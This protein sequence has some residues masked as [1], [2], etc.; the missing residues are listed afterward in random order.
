MKKTVALDVDGVLAQYNGWKGID[1]IGDP[2]PG[3]ISFTKE[4]SEFA[5]ILIYTTRCCETLNDRDGRK[6]SELQQIVK[7]WL[8]KHGFTYNEIYIGQGK[9]IFSCIIDDRAIN[10]SPQI[11]TTSRLNGMSGHIYDITIL[12][13]RAFCGTEQDTGETTNGSL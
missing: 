4:L 9:P 1:H 6:A 5:Y 2:I 10:C 13:A 3:A 12:R 11:N 7:A 8:D